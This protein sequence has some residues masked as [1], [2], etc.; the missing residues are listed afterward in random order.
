MK[1][2]LAK[3][4][5]VLAAVLLIP[6]VAMA[7]PTLQLWS[8]SAVYDPATE[9]WVTKSNPFTLQVLGA[10]SPASVQVIS[11]VTL[12]VSVPEDFNPLGFVTIQGLPSA[13]PTP[14]RIP[15]TYYRLGLGGMGFYEYGTPPG[16]PSH[17]A[18]PAY[19]RGVA[20]EDLMVGTAGETVPDYT[21][22]DTGAGT[23][24]IQRY[25][26]SWYG[27]PYVHFDLTGIGYDTSNP[28]DAGKVWPRFAPFSHDLTALPEPATLFL[29]AGGLAGLVGIRRRLLK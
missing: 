2:A 8:D 1:P 12:Y 11:G 3:A 25:W 6:A 26:V 7:V 22:D 16:L 20:L 18:F 19:Y 29:L 27:F 5:V 23:G 10:R 17:D 9:T 14:D 28:L 13:P 4:C 21:P 24:D 15:Y